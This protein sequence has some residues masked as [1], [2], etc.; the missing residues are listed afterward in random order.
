M[1]Q[2]DEGKNVRGRLRD[3]LSVFYDNPD[4]DITIGYLEKTFKGRYD[5][6]QL[7]ASMA[8]VCN[9]RLQA[10]YRW[11]IQKV[12]SGVWRRVDNNTNSR[13]TEPVTVQ[14]TVKYS[15]QEILVEV[16]KERD[17]YLLVED[18]DDGKIYKMTLVG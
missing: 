10:K 9:P 17:T 18:V 12:T 4:K 11:P 5:R 7:M 13:V 2:S 15:K 14:P 3:V 16:L 1:T 8:H 6:N